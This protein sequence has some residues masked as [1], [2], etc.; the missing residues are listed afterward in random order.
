VREGIREEAEVIRVNGQMK[1]ANI[2]QNREVVHIDN[3]EKR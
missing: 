1:M 2:I 3:I